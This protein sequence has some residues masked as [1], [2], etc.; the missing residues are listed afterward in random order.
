MPLR[1]SRL[2]SSALL[3]KVECHK[4]LTDYELLG[5]LMLQRVA[6]LLRVQDVYSTSCVRPLMRFNVEESLTHTRPLALNVHVCEPV[7]AFSGIKSE[8]KVKRD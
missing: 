4:C 6:R 1:E 3:S 8:V 7:A 5:K 2:L